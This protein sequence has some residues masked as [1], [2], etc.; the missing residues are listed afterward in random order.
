MSEEAARI[1]ALAALP[2]IEDCCD[3]PKSVARSRPLR[4][5][6]YPLH[7]IITTSSSNT[8]P[9]HSPCMSRRS[10][11]AGSNVSSKSVRFPDEIS[12]FRFTHSREQYDRSPIIPS[13]EDLEIPSCKAVDSGS[14]R[15]CL[16]K[17]AREAALANQPPPFIST[18]WSG[19]LNHPTPISPS[20]AVCPSLVHEDWS[21]SSESEEHLSPTN[22][23]PPPQHD[24][25]LPLSSELLCKSLLSTSE[26]TFSWDSF[27]SATDSYD[28]DAEE[29]DDAEGDTICRKRD[30]LSEGDSDEE[31]EDRPARICSL[32]GKISRTELYSEVDCLGGF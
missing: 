10:S 3:H 13:C 9:T 15:T 11:S 17:K 30:R 32:G 2:Q 7:S 29:D 6:I 12:T 26:K 14:W 25:Y 18:V 28:D 20:S 4:P 23:T 16:Q 21:S 31:D 22:L 27:R 5:A 24:S 19:D 1:S 8:S